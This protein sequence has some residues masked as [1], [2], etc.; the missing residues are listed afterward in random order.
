MDDHGPGQPG[1][2]HETLF[3]GEKKTKAK[4]ARGIAQAVESLP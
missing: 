2:K 1:H 4:R 3:R